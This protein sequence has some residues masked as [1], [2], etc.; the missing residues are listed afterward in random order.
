MTGPSSPVQS[1]VVTGPVEGAGRPAED[2]KGRLWRQSLREMGGQ[3]SHQQYA[4]YRAL[5]VAGL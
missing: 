2:L 3:E 4:R 5:L 1:G